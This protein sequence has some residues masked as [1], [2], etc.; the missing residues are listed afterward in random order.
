MLSGRAALRRMDGALKSARRDLERLDS[1]LQSSAR[2]ISGNKLEQARAID[3]MASVRLDAAR[4]GEVVAHLEAANREAS[5]L[6]EARE[7]AIA[8]LVDDIRAR[9]AGIE[10]A[11]DRRGRLHERVDAAATLL[12]QREA[13]VQRALQ[14]DDAFLEQLSHTQAA[15]AIAVS[16][17]EK[18]Q[19][20]EED[21]RH[22]GKPF[23]ADELFM[24][25]WKR[26]YG[27][28]AYSANPLARLLDAW[29][30]RLCGYNGARA[31]YWMLLEIPKRLAEHAD[32]AREA[33][34]QELERLEQIEQKAASDSGV[35][36]ARDELA[37][38][39]QTQDELDQEIATLEEQQSAAQTEQA[40]FAAGEDDHLSSALRVFSAA[41]ERRDI[42]ELMHLALATMTTEDDEVVDELRHLRRQYAELEIELSEHRDLQRQR[43]THLRELE[44][45]RRNFKRRRYDDVHSR[46]DKG[47]TIERMI[48]EVLAGVIQGNSLWNVL[49]RYQRYN[50]VAGEWPDFGSGGIARPRRRQRPKRRRRSSSWHWP[51]VSRSG[52]GG[53][54]LP[55]PRGR[56]GGRGGFRTG[57]GF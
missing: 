37:E 31:N 16:A 53:F 1:E 17:H 57:G 25:L 49:R 44:G 39:E 47:D 6:L 34:E 50:D 28:S 55:R 56:S 13:D 36:A 38:L 22:K 9:R 26:G 29:V 24:Y 52:R 4:R 14:G 32:H 20:A 5:A 23:E 12:A 41:M 7:Q 42:D 27:T 40:R 19:V 8:H 3:R 18:A 15:D 45:V 35:P 33:A 30:A 10:D 51:G 46:F 43:L 21:R 2:A 11:E 48:G 54:K